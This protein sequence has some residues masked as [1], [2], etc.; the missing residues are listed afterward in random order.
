MRKGNDIVPLGRVSSSLS[1][2]RNPLLLCTFF[3]V[4]RVSRWKE[5][6]KSQGKKTL[7]VG[8]QY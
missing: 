6:L 5:T 7:N 4:T 8:D 1:V 3:L 2:I